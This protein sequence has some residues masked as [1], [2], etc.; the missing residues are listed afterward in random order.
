MERPRADVYPL[1]KETWQYIPDPD[2]PGLALRASAR[3][4]LYDSLY[5]VPMPKFHSGHV[6]FFSHETGRLARLAVPT[7]DILSSIWGIAQVLDG[8]VPL[9][10]SHRALRKLIYVLKRSREKFPFPHV[11][12][13]LDDAPLNRALRE[14]RETI[15]FPLFG[16]IEDAIETL[17]DLRGSITYF[18]FPPNRVFP[19]SNEGE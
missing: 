1:G 13:C 15:P 19:S 16:V 14:A 5:H 11:F 3:S 6:Y 9:S 18:R 4:S 2:R 17:R 10:S 8:L 12:A 7:H